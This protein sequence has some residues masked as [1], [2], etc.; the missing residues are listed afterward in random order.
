MTTITKKDL[1]MINV[2]L[3]PIKECKN[4]KSFWMVCVKCNKCGRFKK[5]KI[6]N[7]NNN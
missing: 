6:K 2:N 3:E 4:P 5:K 7:D 1:R